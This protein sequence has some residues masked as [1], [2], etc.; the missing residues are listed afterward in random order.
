LE[1]KSS[2]VEE[3]KTIDAEM[4]KEDIEAKIEVK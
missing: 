2:S 3:I 1:N 4:Q